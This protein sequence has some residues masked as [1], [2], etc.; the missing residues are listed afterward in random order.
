MEQAK[1]FGCGR[2][3]AQVYRG[4]ELYVEYV[5]ML[6]LLGH[7]QEAYDKIMAHKFHPWEG[8]EGKMIT[9]YAVSLTQMACA[10]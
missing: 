4:G 6:N 10:A 8:G 3:A 9:Q 1:H 2:P 5:T 7:Y